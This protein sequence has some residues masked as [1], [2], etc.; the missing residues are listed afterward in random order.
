ME[1]KWF[2]KHNQTVCPHSAHSKPSNTIPSTSLWLLV[3][4]W[5]IQ[6][7]NCRWTEQILAARNSNHV[8]VWINTMLSLQFVW[9]LGEQSSGWSFRLLGYC[10]RRSTSA[11]DQK[12][13]VLIWLFGVWDALL[14]VVLTEMSKIIVFHIFWH[15]LSKT[16][17]QL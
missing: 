17:P 16:L 1:C 8:C 10:L 12:D 4:C 3:W 14:N 2:V 15:F 5:Q 6:T 9:F 13:I 11:L 7:H